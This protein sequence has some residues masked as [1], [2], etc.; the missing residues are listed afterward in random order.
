MSILDGYSKKSAAAYN[1]NFSSPLL[2]AP[3]TASFMTKKKKEEMRK[4]Q[5]DT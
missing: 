5:S 2:R 3:L 4:L 1:Q